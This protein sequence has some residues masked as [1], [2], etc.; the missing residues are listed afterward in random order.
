MKEIVSKLR[1]ILSPREKRLAILLFL[2]MLLG[3]ALEMLGVG[4]I[5]AF[6]TLLSNP[7][8]VEQFRLLAPARPFFANHDPSTIVLIGACVLLLLFLV[9]NIYLSC[10]TVLTSRYVTRRQIGIARRLFG[11]YLQMPY[12][13]HLQR[14]TAELLRNANNEAL[15]VVGAVLMPGLTLLMETLT[16]SGILLLLFLAEPFISLLAFILLGGATFLFVRGMRRRML[17]YGQLVQDYRLKMI[18]TVNE[19]LGGFKIT[20]V[21]GR[22]GHFLGAYGQ[23][24]DQFAEAL[25]YRQIMTELPRLYLETVAMF[26]MLGVA[27]LL[28]AQH[29][30][31]QA[32]IPTLSILA[33]AIV[34]MIPSFNRI[35]TSLTSIRYGRFSLDVVHADLVSLPSE[36]AKQVHREKD[37]G[38]EDSIRLEDVTF[39]YPGAATDS[40]RNVSL[41]IPR[42]SAVAFVG[43]TGSGKTTLVDLILGLLGP[44][45]GRI[46]IDDV[47]LSDR[48]SEWQRHIGYVPQDI[49][50][51][52]DTIRRNIAF[53]LPDDAIDNAAVSNAAEAAQL[54]EFIGSLPQG[55]D[56]MVG[57]RGVRLSGG[58]RQRIG[59]ARAL[60]HEPDVLILD[61][62]TSSLDNE[63]ERYVMQAID[64]LRG[65]RTIIVIAHRMSTVRNCDCL[66]LLREGAVVTSGR[67]DELMSGSGEFRRLAA[68]I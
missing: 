44:T 45:A 41:S 38:F 59:I 17:H 33:V 20:R 66:F 37:R 29:R 65:H 56:T 4:A 52:D 12:T 15:D 13:L 34:R 3:A 58:Q 19:A 48:V 36:G 31:V 28:I 8:K 24:A 6:I 16:A 67:Y 55:F 9:K 63:T 68:V 35:T 61:E 51:T 14:N 53:G 18:Q 1:D 2:M 22:E 25:R 32:I 5:P 7:G 43:P 49:F 50:L 62:A 39:Q 42:G 40:L 23:Q 10:L 54:T 60:Y 30:P 46:L 27:A 64:F 11:V 21:L 47:D 26:G 57:E